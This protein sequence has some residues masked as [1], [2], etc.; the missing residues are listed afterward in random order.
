MVTPDVK[1]FSC[2][3]AKEMVVLTGLRIDSK[4]RSIHCKT[5]TQFLRLFQAKTDNFSYN[6]SSFVVQKAKEGTGRVVMWKEFALIYS[7]TLECSFMGPT[8][9]IY[10]DCHFTSEMLIV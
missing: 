10:K 5:R 3:D 7:Y 8:S 1:T 2:M 9:G 6:D 4:R